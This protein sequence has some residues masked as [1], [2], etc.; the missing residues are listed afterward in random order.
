MGRS[1]V[2]IL[3]MR[4]EERDALGFVLKSYQVLTEGMDFRCNSNWVF[5]FFSLLKKE[6]LC[7]QD[8]FYAISNDAICDYYF[9]LP[10][11]QGTY[12]PFILV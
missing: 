4:H 3:A 12:L 11:L 1:N 2:A 8:Q 5:I 7:L 9:S 10:L 6:K